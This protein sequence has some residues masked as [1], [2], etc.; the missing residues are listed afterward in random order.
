M[1]WMYASK[2]INHTRAR[3]VVVIELLELGIER[4]HAE[5]R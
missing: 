1:S 4:E 3:K 5:F 2:I